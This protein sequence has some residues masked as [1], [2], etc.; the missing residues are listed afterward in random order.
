MGDECDKQLNLVIFVFDVEN[1]ERK[2][3]KFFGRTCHRSLSVFMCQFSHS[4]TTS[5]CIRSNNVIHYMSRKNKMGS[6]LTSTVGY[7]LPSP[8]L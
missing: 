2:S 6:N 8:K 3:R 5:M 4:F 1:H 7:I